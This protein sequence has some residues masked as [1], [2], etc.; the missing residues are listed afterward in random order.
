MFYGGLA[1]TYDEFKRQLGK[2]G[3]TAREFAELV[4]LHPNSITNYGQQGEVPSHLAIIVTLMGEMAENG[5]D[6]RAV[7]SR[8]D[9]ESNRPRGAAAKGRFGG[10]KQIMLQLPAA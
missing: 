4:K 1:V 8:I 6:F 7:L 9:I 3:L 2:A 10:D 5:L